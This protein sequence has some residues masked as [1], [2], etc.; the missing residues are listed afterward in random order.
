[1]QPDI[2]ST[3]TRNQRESKIAR[4]CEMIASS[5]ETES[6]MDKLVALSMRTGYELGKQTK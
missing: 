5:D 6:E 2:R 4:M 1:M 3:E